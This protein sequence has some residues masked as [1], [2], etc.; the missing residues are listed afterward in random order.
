LVDTLG[1]YVEW[2][3]V[4]PEVECGLGIPREPIRLVGNAAAPRLMTIASGVDITERMRTWVH[5]HL[6]R[7]ADEDIRG[8]VFKNRSPSC[9]L[10]RV[11]VYDTH[12][13]GAN[14]IPT[15]SGLFA[16]AFVSRFPLLPVEE[17]GRLHDALLRKNFVERVF[18]FDRW[19][20]Y[21]C[22]DGSRDGL[23]EFHERNR[24]LFMSHSP[25][26]LRRLER[27]V[28]SP[29]RLPLPELQACYLEQFMDALRLI[30]TVEKH[31]AVLVRISGMLRGHLSADER[32]ELHEV[33]KHYRQGLTPLVVPL[34][35]IQHYVRKSPA[36]S[37]R[38]QWYLHPEPDELG[39]F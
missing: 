27:L 30:A 29:Q 39:G 17:E 9:G 34:T 4:C 19:R 23:I 15:G 11:K 37:L 20:Q 8:F 1:G 28:T 32:A 5:Q 13:K 25:A 36:T 22:T 10:Y 38:K 2:V 6:T 14:S 21:V 16:G 33:I 7:L 3:P 35:L 24:L 18:T 12:V 31:T 26:H